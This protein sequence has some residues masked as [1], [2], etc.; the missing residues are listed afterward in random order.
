MNFPTKRNRRGCAEEIDKQD[1]VKI[2][3]KLFDSLN[4]YRCQICGITS[5]EKYPRTTNGDMSL[6]AC[7][8]CSPTALQ[9]CT[10]GDEEGIK[11]SPKIEKTSED[12]ALQIIR[13]RY[14]KGE[15][16]KEQYEQMKEDLEN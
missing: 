5:T 14:A 1:E 6:F 7:E 15:I 3:Y 10:E 4:G 11:P 12:E 13:L 8:K 9:I 16:T 2:H